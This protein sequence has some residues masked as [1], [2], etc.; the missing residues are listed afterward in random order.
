MSVSGTPVRSSQPTILETKVFKVDVSVW[1]QLSC[2]L[3]KSVHEFCVFF[4]ADSLL[5][6]AKVEFIVEKSLVV[7]ATVK[8]HR[9][10]PIR[11][12]TAAE[13]GKNEFG[14]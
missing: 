5:L 13:S 7:G 9:K 2:R 10:G 4:T 6:E 12:D 1:I 11:M 8:N 3:D 14:N